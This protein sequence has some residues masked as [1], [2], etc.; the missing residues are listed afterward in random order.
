MKTFMKELPN[1]NRIEVDQFTFMQDKLKDAFHQI[2]RT[3]TLT[4][5]RVATPGSRP[6]EPRLRFGGTHRQ[7]NF[8][9]TGKAAHDP[10]RKLATERGMGVDQHIS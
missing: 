5:Y 6:A 9:K 7:R 10:S 4:I 3:S 2:I 8:W 1:G